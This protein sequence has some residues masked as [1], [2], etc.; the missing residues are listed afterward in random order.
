MSE[1]LPEWA[2][3]E[4][5]SIRDESFNVVDTWEGTG[6]FLDI[7]EKDRK[8]DIQFY[9]KLPIGRHIVTV[10]TPD[11]IDMKKFMK[12]FV[13][14]YKIKVLKAPFSERLT[15]YLKERL[16]LNMDG[17]YRFILDSYEL[18]D[19]VSDT[20]EVQEDDND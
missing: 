20:L 5:N 10:E 14:T 7:D 6:Y 9:E 13:Y 12:G 4:I 1:E 11:S 18:L 16:N 17:V 19:D 8:V 3:T 15:K 2:E